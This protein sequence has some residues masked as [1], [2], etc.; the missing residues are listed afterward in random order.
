MIKT[1]MEAAFGRTGAGGAISLDIWTDPYRQISYLGMIVHYINDNFELCQR[2]IACKSLRSDKK[3]NA[4]YLL[5]YWFWM[6]S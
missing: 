3:K 4:D 6:T 1:E 5:S 2:T